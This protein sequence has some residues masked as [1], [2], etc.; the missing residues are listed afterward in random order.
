MDKSLS[1]VN[2]CSLNLEM[3][4]IETEEQAEAKGERDFHQLIGLRNENVTEYWPDTFPQRSRS[5]KYALS[6]YVVIGTI[7]TLHLHQICQLVQSILL[8]MYN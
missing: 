2:S 7:F 5:L 4:E 8:L 6:L 3:K 1:E